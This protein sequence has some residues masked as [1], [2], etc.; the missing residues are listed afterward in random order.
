MG[1]QAKIRAERRRTRALA[2]A[3]DA[4]GVSERVRAAYLA[5]QRPDVQA[6]I[7]EKSTVDRAPWT[8]QVPLVQVAESALREYGYDLAGVCVT[9]HYRPGEPPVVWFKADASDEA[10]KA[11]GFAPSKATPCH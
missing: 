6:R 4:S 9:A 8:D 5:L 7:R 1:L 2:D 10:V 11:A 3:L